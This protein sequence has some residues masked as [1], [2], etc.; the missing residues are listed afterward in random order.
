MSPY[1]WQA[2]QQR[3]RPGQQDEGVPALHGPAAVGLQ[4][5][6]DGVVPVHRH[7]HNHV[8]RDKHPEHLQVFHQPAQE[9]R[10][11][12][13]TF[14]IPHQLGQHL[15]G[16]EEGEEG[17]GETQGGGAL[18][19]CVHL[20]VCV[21]VCVCVTWKNATTRSATQRLSMNWCSGLW[22]P[23]R[24]SSTTSTSPLPSSAITKMTA[25]TT[26]SPT[27]RRASRSQSVT[28]VPAGVTDTTDQSMEGS[29]SVTMVTDMLAWME[30][31]RSRGEEE[32]GRAEEMLKKSLKEKF[33]GS[34]RFVLLQEYIVLHLSISLVYCNVIFLLH[35]NIVLFTQHLL[36]LY[37]KINY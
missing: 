28:F 32:R 30:R 4:G 14:S 20:C 12:K 19:V 37:A 5:T 1:L 35:E 15:R 6:A 34:P 23:L 17:W 8:G 22:C 10:A 3:Q 33:S 11:R 29:T 21:Y 31:K 24:L 16:E 9:V 2:E 27:A 26:T 18:S 13:A 7:S 25:N 36:H